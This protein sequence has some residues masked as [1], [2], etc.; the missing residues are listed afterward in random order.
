MAWTEQCKIAFTT[1]ADV[2]YWKQKGRKSKR[3][4]LIG[5]AKDSGISLRTLQ[6]WWE[7]QEC[8]KSGATETTTTNNEEKRTDVVVDNNI[9]CVTCKINPPRRPGEKQCAACVSKRAREKKIKWLHQVGGH[10]RSLIKILE[11][12]STHKRK[13]KSGIT[14]AEYEK[15]MEGVFSLIKIWEELSQEGDDK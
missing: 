12:E 14:R 11:V 6:R 8:A 15:V 2:L 10:I 7:E 5:L 9:L 3:K 1:N 4:V 13:W